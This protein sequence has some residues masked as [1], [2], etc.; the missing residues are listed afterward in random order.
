MARV[1]IHILRLWPWGPRAT[2]HG[3]RGPLIVDRAE[4]TT[5]PNAP[6]RGP[7][8]THCTLRWT[9]AGH[10]ATSRSRVRPSSAPP[11]P[12]A[13]PPR[14][15]PGDP[16]D[17]GDLPRR[18]DRD[19][20][21]HVDAGGA[22]HLLTEQGNRTTLTSLR[23]F[24]NRWEA[25]TTRRLR[26][27]NPQALDAHAEHDRIS[28]SP[29]EAMLEAAHTAWQESEAAGHSAILVAADTQ[30]AVD[31]VTAVDV[32]LGQCV[33]HVN[34]SREH[35]ARTRRGLAESPDVRRDN[36]AV[37]G[38]PRPGRVPHPAVGCASMDE[39]DR[40][41]TARARAVV[42]DAGGGVRSRG[43]RSLLG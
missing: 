25:Q 10:R 1:D 18:T 22:F 15:H 40:P 32:D 21:R 12:H 14:P 43:R 9:T 33:E 6:R 42:G 4:R 23:W 27:G 30:G 3:G 41:V 5:S 36:I 26:T 31:E 34:D 19:T 2:H 16:G 17:D 24:T 20:G 11:S 28:T 39:D 13:T 8:A 35:A 7:G 29:G 37:G 38:E